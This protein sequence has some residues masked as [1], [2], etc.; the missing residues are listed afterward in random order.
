M[1]CVAVAIAVVVVSGAS[2]P[3]HAA[4]I[5]NGAL[6]GVAD[7]SIH[8]SV[9]PPGW[10]A[11]QGS[12]DTFDTTTTFANYAWVASAG[13]GTFVHA[14]ASTSGQEAFAQDVTGLVIG[15]SYTITFEQTMAHPDYTQADEGFWRVSFGAETYDSAI[16]TA[17]ALGDSAPWQTQSLSFVASATTQTLNFQART[18]WTIVNSRVDLGIDSIAITSGR[19][20]EPGAC[21][22][23]AL[24]LALAV[25]RR[26]PA[27]ACAGAG[28][29]WPGR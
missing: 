25:R 12:P 22:F 4:T 14:L 1:R 28:R 20:P 11:S 9:V 18:N 8:N 16:M 7:F 21:L 26:G 29:P 23:L 17:P 3:V 5:V 2:A 6:T 24:G 10:T 15:Q 27:T 19:V 13:G